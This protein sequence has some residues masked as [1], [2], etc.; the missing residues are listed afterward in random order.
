MDIPQ[1]M[2]SGYANAKS[3]L[4][5]TGVTQSYAIAYE[6]FRDYDSADEETKKKMVEEYVYRLYNEV[7]VP[8]SKAAH[9]LAD[10]MVS[11]ATDGKARAE[12]DLI[13]YENFRKRSLEKFERY[14]GNDAV[15]RFT[16]YV[17]KSLRKLLAHS[18]DK[19]ASRSRTRSGSQ[20]RFARV[21]VGPTC[22]FCILL[23][24][25]GFVYL[26][27]RSAK[28]V[29]DSFRKFHD[30]CDCSILPEPASGNIQGYNYLEYR[31]R[32]YECQKA[33]ANEI[34]GYNSEETTR[35]ILAE[36]RTRSKEWLYDGTPTEPSIKGNP[37]REELVII[38]TLSEN[39]LRSVEYNENGLKINNR[40]VDIGFQSNER[41]AVIFVPSYEL[42]ALVEQIK[43]TLP[44]GITVTLVSDDMEIRRIR[45]SRNTA[46]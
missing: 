37:T 38:Q 18:P 13:S 15:E 45:N 27:E 41:D 11:Y 10:G 9:Q 40:Y 2:V 46:E 4:A 44:D 19:S 1:S 42:D 39:G 35:A 28:Y 8:S 23:A 22:A 6:V 25:Q 3:N 34:K 17:D 12:L 14:N 26:S 43:A 7:V 31:A 36:M 30:D 24:S 20:V 32:Y 5:K 29:G 21:P 33:I 16:A